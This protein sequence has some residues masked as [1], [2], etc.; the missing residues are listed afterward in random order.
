MSCSAMI[1]EL[2]SAENDLMVLSVM[3]AFSPGMFVSRSPN[4]YKVLCQTGNVFKVNCY[5]SR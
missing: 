3:L 1:K 2:Y 4:Y 5:T